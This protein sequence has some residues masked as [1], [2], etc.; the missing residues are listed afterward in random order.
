M[1]KNMNESMQST[2]G[3]KTPYRIGN[4]AA[5]SLTCMQ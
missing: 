1:D 4:R 5:G 3:L 2:G